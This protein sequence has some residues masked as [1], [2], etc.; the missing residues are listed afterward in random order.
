MNDTEQACGRWGVVWQNILIRDG[1]DIGKGKLR[2]IVVL[3]VMI[4]L[5]GALFGVLYHEQEKRIAK[6][7][8]NRRA[9]LE[10]QQIIEQDRKQYFESVAAKRAEL[11][12]G[13]TESKNQYEELLKNQSD[14]IAKN[15]KT[16]TQ[17]VTVPVQ[18]T[19]KTPVAVSKP[20]ATRKTKSS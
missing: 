2:F 10:E 7:E 8:W 15:Q 19:V 20:K 11:R 12:S 1:K 16:T 3:V 14:V 4:T 13:M 9:F 18:T 17:T 5:S 6:A